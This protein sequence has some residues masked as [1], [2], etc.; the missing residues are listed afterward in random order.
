VFQIS[1]AGFMFELYFNDEKL[2]GENRNYK[3]KINFE[4]IVGAL[5]DEEKRVVLVWS[6]TKVL[7]IKNDG[8]NNFSY[9]NSFEFLN[10]EKIRDV[11]WNSGLIT[12]FCA[13]TA[14]LDFNCFSTKLL[15]CR[16]FRPTNL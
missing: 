3:R 2:E 9:L 12:I 5:F 8:A 1:D 10:G 6:D 14:I 7:Q 15:D 4:R 16:K 11:Q 13:S